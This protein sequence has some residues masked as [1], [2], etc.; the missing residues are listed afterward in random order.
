MWK[1]IANICGHVDETVKLVLSINGFRS[2]NSF[3]RIT[4][5]E[6]LLLRMTQ[7][8]KNLPPSSK[9]YEKFEKLTGESPANYEIEVGCE[10]S[11]YDILDKMKDCEILAMSENEEV[12]GSAP[13]G[14]KRR[15]DESSNQTSTKSLKLTV[16]N[17]PLIK[18]TLVK[19][20]SSMINIANPSLN[21]NNFE[22]PLNDCNTTDDGATFST[23][24]FLCNT[25]VSV[26]CK[27]MNTGYFQSRIDN[28]T[29]HIERRHQEEGQRLKDFKVK[30]Y[31]T[32][33]IKEN[34]LFLNKALKPLDSLHTVPFIQNSLLYTIEDV[35]NS[36]LPINIS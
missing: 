7:K 10:S 9:Y 18:E 14:K 33:F 27:R 28:Y 3:K 36:Y 12:V 4:I 8:I 25:P 23:F 2:I 13:R 26:S 15:S 21:M 32:N 29:K 6:D 30:K 24:C 31:F 22:V 16:P 35:S 17:V 19:K 1:T 20:I 5:N 34:H 11:I